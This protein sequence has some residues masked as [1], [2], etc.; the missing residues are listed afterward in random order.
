MRWFWI[1]RFTEFVC[2][3]HA[4]AVK[5]ISLSEDHLHD[6]A[7]GYPIMPN[8][9][10]T[11]GMAQAGG[12]LV[13]E[14]YNFVELVVLGKLAKA[15]FYREVRP[16]E[17]LTYRVTLDAV[18]D[19]GAAVQATAH[20]DDQLHAEALLFYARMGEE[21]D[22]LK[23]AR[24]FKPSHLRHWLSLVRVFEVGVRADGSRMREADYPLADRP[25]IG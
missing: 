18:R 3:S 10:V 20:V 6:H 12:L 2:G 23:G 16:G 25:V 5:G 11:E 24:L 8:S 13:S 14:Q 21:N 17:R 22:A 7:V 1:D 15:K 9:L 19:T 4:V